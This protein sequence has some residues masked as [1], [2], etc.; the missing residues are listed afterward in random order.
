MPG[1]PTVRP[2]RLD[3][4]PAV[5][6][7][8]A[9]AFAQDP[10][11]VWFFPGVRRRQRRLERFYA[12]EV[13]TLLDAGEGWVTEDR[14]AAALWLPVGRPPERPPGRAHLGRQLRWNLAA[15][16]LLGRRL[17]RAAATMIRVQQRHPR[18][19]HWYLACLGTA[20]ERQGRGLG[21]AVL[22]PVLERCDRTGTPAVLD[23][24][25]A[26]DVRFYQRRGFEVTAEV[27]RP[28]APHLWVMRRAPGAAPAAA[29]TP[30][31]SPAEERV[32]G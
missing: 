31:R 6:R 7:M 30:G 14:E 19:P 24:A 27:A 13:L 32:P 21:S 10:T 23:T 15:A 3:D 17:P 1:V 8:L 20:P 22:A 18:E 25:T 2:L 26:E 9:R 11:T 5:S 29:G 28:G 16:W 12:I 4:V